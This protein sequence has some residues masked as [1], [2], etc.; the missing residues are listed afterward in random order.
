VPRV[1]PIGVRGSISGPVIS[2]KLAVRFNV[3]SFE[4]DGYYDNPVTG[5]DLGAERTLGGAVS[6]LFQATE[7][8]D[9]SRAVPVHRR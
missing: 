5:E 7:R 1:V 4:K 8:S 2:E 6:L 9:R 3:A